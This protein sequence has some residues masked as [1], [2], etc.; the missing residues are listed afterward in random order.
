MLSLGDR[1]KKVIIQYHI[2]ALNVVITKFI[3]QM[4]RIWPFAFFE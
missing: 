1:I 2:Y 4:S 3:L